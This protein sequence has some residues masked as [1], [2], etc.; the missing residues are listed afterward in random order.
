M[1]AFL[2]RAGATDVEEL[3]LAEENV[4]FS[5]PAGVRSIPLDSRPS[6]VGT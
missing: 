1:L 6:G 3:R 4:R 2:A 5:L